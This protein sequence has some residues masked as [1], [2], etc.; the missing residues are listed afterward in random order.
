MDSISHYM[1]KIL[2]RCEICL[3]G[4]VISQEL[5]MRAFLS[6][7][8]KTIEKDRHNINIVL[9]TGS[10]CFDA[11]LLSYI[12]ISNILYNETDPIELVH[13][14]APGDLVMYQKQRYEFMG[15]VNDLEGTLASTEM[16]TDGEFVVLKQNNNWATVKKNNWGK[17]LPYQGVSKRLDGRGLR[18]DKGI[19]NRFFNEVLSFD[20]SE[21]PAAVDVS[22]IVLMPKNDATSLIQGLS[23][24]FA[25]VELKYT[26]LINV[27]YYTDVNHEYPYGGNAAR[28]EPVIKITSKAE[29][30]RKLIRK[31][32]C[33]RN[34][35]LVV[36]GNEVFQRGRFELPELIERISLQYVYLC[37]DIAFD[38]GSTLL[39]NYR[40]ANLFACTKE[41]LL[42]NA[43]KSV[44][45]NK[46]TEQ[47][48]RQVDAILAHKVED[49]RI[50][51]IV[52]W[53]KYKQY[54]RAI[55]SIK[56]SEFDSN[57]KENFVIQAFSL[58]N[59][60]MTSIFPISELE[61]RILEGTIENVG[62]VKK[63][64]EKMN[65]TYL[66]FP[67]Y[68]H[69]S[70]RIIIDCLLETYI[71]VFDDSPKQI[72]LLELLRRNIGKRVCIV[73][74]KAYYIPMAKNLV[75]GDTTAITTVNKFDNNRL[76]D[77]IICVGNIS[78]RNFDIFRCKSAAKIKVLLYDAET[79][80]YKKHYREEIKKEHFINQKS[81]LFVPEYSTTDDFVDRELEEQ[82]IINEIDQL[83]INMN[84]FLG[85]SIAKS[86]RSYLESS[87]R[88]TTSEI[89][90]VARF[91]TDEVAFFTKH[92]KAYVLDQE[93][94][95][96]REVKVEELSEG[97]TV[98]FTRSNSKTRDIVDSILQELVK[99]YDLPKE[100]SDAYWKSKAWRTKLI[101]FMNANSL[102]TKQ[103]VKRMK[104][105]GVR[106]QEATIRGWLDEDSH[107][108]GPREV[109]SIEQIAV[110]IGDAEMLENSNLYFDAC[111]EIRKVRRKIL[112]AIA[113]ATLTK[114]SGN[115]LKQDSFLATVR[116]QLDDW[117]VEL[118]IEN[119]I[120]MNEEVP[121]YMINRPVSVGM[122]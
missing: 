95:T 21:I 75:I 22:T 33:N 90:A 46:E 91:D 54:K 77:L 4:C 50:T 94:L 30:A 3:D 12:A 68:L 38:S 11:V 86:A 32:E 117:A 55:I 58:M 57:D 47:L 2:E 63:R 105:N 110:V 51:E 88:S 122:E 114:L 67:Q 100:L 89:V 64:I 83:D 9:H 53:N 73:V 43:S 102:S 15:F 61:S 71:K 6:F 39:T 13:S 85:S 92:Y 45:Q 35:G 36:L 41:F 31:K 76:Y 16:L 29:V 20:E 10:V 99:N 40:D 42:S 62:S 116:G 104:K 28:I 111:V 101:D 19:R 93:S 107:T 74:P 72:K 60:F 108:V 115:E 103:I 81:T 120:F 70:A 8:S 87:T 24:K 113:K 106:V 1:K 98:V 66:N 17:I 7:I 79:Y 44:V 37:M 65:E 69:E 23:F 118:S 25:G 97:D 84:E 78:G 27:S 112:D 18:R 109:S 26:D 121:T 96:T 34:I 56:S 82:E 48:S 52:G 80:L 119:I 59:L 5:L 14:L 49:I